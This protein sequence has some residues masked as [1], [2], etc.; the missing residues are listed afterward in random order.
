MSAAAT[1]ILLNAASANVNYYPQRIINGS[2]SIYV[3]RTNGVLAAQSRASLFFNE[4][5]VTR[6]VVGKVT[7]PVLNATTGALSHTLIGT[8]EFKLPLISTLTERQEVRKRLTS[9]IGLAITSDAT[10][11]GETPW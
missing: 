9:L 1:I 8:Y 11:N 10:D 3:D 4:S 6:K 7:Y 5:A 2:E